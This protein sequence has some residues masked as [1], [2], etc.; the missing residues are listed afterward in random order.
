MFTEGE[1]SGHNGSSVNPKSDHITWPD[2]FPWNW[3][4]VGNH[5]VTGFLRLIQM[6]SKI[7]RKWS[8]L[9]SEYV[10]QG[11][12]M[13]VPKYDDLMKSLLLA[14]QDGGIYKIKDVIATLAQ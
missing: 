10:G 5:A 8:N 1:V 2:T 11:V 12:N 7:T 3:R 14:V 4:M 13:P 9:K 6:V